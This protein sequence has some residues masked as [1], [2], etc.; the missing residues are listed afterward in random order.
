MRRLLALSATPDNRAFLLVASGLCSIGSAC[1]SV[2]QGPP[3]PRRRF[4]IPE[5]VIR[6]AEVERPASARQRYGE[7]V[8]TQVPDTGAARYAFE[9][10]LVR[11]V[12]VATSK[13]IHFDLTN[14]TQYSVRIPWDEVAF[15]DTAKQSH[16]VM[17]VGVKYTDCSA[18]K[19]PSV[20]VQRGSVSDVMIP[21]SNVEFSLGDW[22]VNGFLPDQGDLA[23]SPDSILASIKPEIGKR[24]Q[25]LLPLQIQDVTNEY[26]FTF[27]VVDVRV[28]TL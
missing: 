4:Q 21:C 17:H 19:P 27:E 5:Y 24:V 28:R 16:P 1:A 20:V 3:E 25:V 2:P 14:K 11:I 8:I 18:S 10:N 15:V 7:Q 23:V 6:L 9:D 26:L 13:R 22:R 12:W